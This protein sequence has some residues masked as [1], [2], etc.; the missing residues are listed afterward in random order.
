MSNFKI[1]N[2]NKL[3]FF[4]ALITF[5]ALLLFIILDINRFISILNWALNVSK[6]LLVGFC[7]AFIINLL[8]TGLDKL[9]FNRIHFKK[10]G[11]K[12]VISLL[13]SMILLLVILAAILW[14][15]LPQIV[16]SIELLADSLPK[17]FDSARK[18][19]ETFIE[20]NPDVR[21]VINLIPVNIDSIG[22]DLGSFIRSTLSSTLTQSY[23]IASNLISLVFTLFIGIMFSFFVILSQKKIGR[24]CR[25]LLYTYL[26]DKTASK[27][28][29][30]F[31]LAHNYF[32]AFIYGQCLEALILFVLYL[33]V[34][35]LFRIPYAFM[36]AIMIM[37]F[38]LIP[39]FGAY[40]AWAIG[41]FLII[42]VNPIQA[43]YFTIIFLVIS[44]IEGNL[45]YPR[46][47]G[48]TIGLPGIWVLAAV[49]I[50]GNML[51]VIGMI[52]SVPIVAIIYTLLS[53]N[54]QKRLRN[55]KHRI[56]QIINPPDWHYYNPETMDFEKEPVQLDNVLEKIDDQTTESEGLD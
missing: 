36:I 37:I 39:L 30:I 45:I 15:I 29:Y 28:L 1:P 11:I 23:K 31:H 54:S 34:A 17:A 41:I 51:G 44:Q 19:L 56:E 2:K 3:K 21:E 5:S 4:I 18:T 42:P 8:M 52:I 46:I 49:T 7:I 13:T 40:I 16:K 24:Q 50:G 38:S 6:P 55:K 26:P 12:Q 43:V 32:S 22:S 14:V 25:Q 35:L 53:E 48:S 27:T 20:S 10:D 9:I 47:V 33:I